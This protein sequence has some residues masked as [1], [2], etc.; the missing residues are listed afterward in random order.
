M[1]QAER[2]YQDYT[3]SEYSFEYTKVKGSKKFSTHRIARKY[4]DFYK[5]KRE[6]EIPGFIKEIIDDENKLMTAIEDMYA[7]KSVFNDKNI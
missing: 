2:D 6:R 5:R 1:T 7:I 3:K 4:Q